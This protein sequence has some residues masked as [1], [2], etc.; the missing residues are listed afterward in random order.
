M[1]GFWTATFRTPSRSA[2]ASPSSPTPKSSAATPP[3]PT[4][5]YHLDGAGISARLRIAPFNSTA[6]NV[7]GG[8]QSFDLT[9]TGKVQGSTMTGRGKASH[10]PGI[11]FEVNPHATQI[12][13]G[14]P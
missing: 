13:K 9:I 3:S 7:F 10:Y 4:W 1:N 2:T 5:P 14:T 8:K 6:N 12:T 11:D